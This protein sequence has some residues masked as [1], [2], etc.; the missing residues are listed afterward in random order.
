M[1]LHEREHAVVLLVEESAR[2]VIGAGPRRT[3]RV[4]K[5]IAITALFLIF[6]LQG[7]IGF[8]VRV[9][10]IPVSILQILWISGCSGSAHLLQCGDILFHCGGI[11]LLVIVLHLHVQDHGLRRMY[12]EEGANL[13]HHPVKILEFPLIIQ[14][15]VHEVNVKNG[16]IGAVAFKQFVEIRVIDAGMAVCPAKIQQ[17]D[18]GVQLIWD[19]L[20]LGDGLFYL[21]SGKLRPGP[22]TEAAGVMGTGNVDLVQAAV[23]GDPRHPVGCVQQIRFVLIG[24]GRSRRFNCAVLF[25]GSGSKLPVRLRSQ[26]IHP[27]HRSVL[28]VD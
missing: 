20:I 27:I 22:D 23:I 10:V 26:N 16:T 4:N 25:V 13:I 21:V 14:A 15:I 2:R 5:R 11:L 8:I 17:S 12:I 18:A 1:V 3:V 7:P 6:R 19:G 28:F 9:S 24:H